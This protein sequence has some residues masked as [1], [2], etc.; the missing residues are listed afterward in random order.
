[1]TTPKDVAQDTDLAI[2]RILARYCHLVDDHDFDATADLFTDDARLRLAGETFEGR[3][4]IRT[5]LDSVPEGLCHQVSNVVVSN[6]SQTDT[7]HALSDLIVTRKSE[8]GWQTVMVG[9]YHDT[10]VGEGRSLLFSQRI[11]TVR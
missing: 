2:R 3:G 5:W 7:Y 6:G 1:M 8:S 10:F 11:V 9:R 4:A